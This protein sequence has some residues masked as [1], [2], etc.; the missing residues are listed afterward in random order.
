MAVKQFDRN[1][2]QR[3]RGENG[4]NCDIKNLSQGLKVYFPVFVDGTNLSMGDIHF[5][6]GDAESH[7]VELCEDDEFITLACEYEN[8]DLSGIRSVDCKLL[9]FHLIENSTALN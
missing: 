3:N 8:K 4:R 7:V 9:G 6:Q 1:R 2:L 5:S